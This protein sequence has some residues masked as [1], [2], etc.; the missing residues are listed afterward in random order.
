MIS[1]VQALAWPLAS[2]FKQTSV[3]HSHLNILLVTT[4]M[5]HDIN[6]EKSLCG[7]FRNDP[8][9][10]GYKYCGID[11]PIKLCNTQ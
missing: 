10:D 1:A 11:V 5:I 9:C 8:Y 7:P 3:Q 6:A 4:D 2:E